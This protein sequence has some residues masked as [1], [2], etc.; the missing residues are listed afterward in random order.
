MTSIAILGHDGAVRITSSFSAPSLNAIVADRGT[1]GSPVPIT[2]KTVWSINPHNTVLLESSDSNARIVWDDG[3]RR[4]LYQSRNTSHDVWRVQYAWTK[5][6]A[7]ENLKGSLQWVVPN[8]DAHQDLAGVTA[9]AM[10]TVNA[11][12]SQPSD[13]K[14]SISESDD[15]ESSTMNEQTVS[16]I[17]PA[18]IIDDASDDDQKSIDDFSSHET[19]APITVE[20]LEPDTAITVDDHV[21]DDSTAITTVSAAAGIDGTDIIA[22]AS[23]DV[24]GMIALIPSRD[25]VERLAIDG[26]ETKDQ[27][28][29]TLTYLGKRAGGWPDDIRAA[30]IDNVQTIAR[31]FTPISAQTFF[32]TVFNPSGDQPCVVL[33]VTGDDLPVIMRE[34]R[35][36]AYDILGDDVPLQHSPWIPHITLKYLQNE[37]VDIQSFTDT[38]IG[39]VTFDRIRVAFGDSY[40]D[41]PLGEDTTMSPNTSEP[42]T[43][44]DTPEWDGELSFDADGHP[45]VPNVLIPMHV[46]QKERDVNEPSGVG[47]NLRNYWVRGEG[48][49]KIRWGTDGS[50]QRCIRYLSDYVVDPGGLCAEYHHAATGEWPRGGNVPSGADVIAFEDNM[51]DGEHK[52]DDMEHGNDDNESMPWSG[53][54][55]VEGI[56]SGDGRVFAPYALTWDDPPL[57]LL[58]QKETSHGGTNDVTVRVGNIDKIWREPDPSGRRDVFFI[59]GAGT[60]DLGNPDGAEIYRRMRRGYMRGNSVDVDSVRDADVQYVY[61]ETPRT[62]G[63]ND[64]ESGMGLDD[65]AQL[66]ARPETM[67]FTKGRIRATTLVEIPAFTEA[68]LS[69]DD[70]ITSSAFASHTSSRASDAPWNAS[71]NLRRLP[72]PVP[73]DVARNVFAWYDEDFVKDGGIPKHAGRFPHHEV[74]ADGTPGAVNLVACSGVIGALNGARGGSSIP[75]SE[76]RAVYNHIAKHMRDADRTPPPLKSLSAVNNLTLTAGAVRAHKTET[77]DTSWDSGVMTKRLSSPLSVADARNVFAWIDESRV[78]DGMMPKGAGKLP[79]HEVNADGTPGPAN[80]TACSAAIGA[81][82]GARGGVDIPASDRQ[83]VYNHLASHLRDA[84]R[85]PPALT[86]S[87]FS[88]DNDALIA[89]TSTITISDVPPREWFDEP[90]DVTPSGALTVT[91]DGRIF[92]YIAPANVRHRSFQD[93]AT[94]VPMKKV[95]YSRFMGGETIVADGGRIATGNITMGCG[96]A[97][98]SPHV[99][100]V[101]AAEHYDNTCS[102]VATVRVGENQH[103]VWMAGALL[104]GLSADHVRRIMACRLSGDWRPHLDRPG[105]REFV[106]ALLVPVP[107]FPM[108]RTA[109][110]VSTRNGALIASSVPVQFILDDTLSDDNVEDANDASA[111]IASDDVNTNVAE[112]QDN[113]PDDASNVESVTCACKD[114]KKA[115]T[116]NDVSASACD[117]VSVQNDSSVQPHVDDIRAR[118]AALRAQHIISG[119]RTENNID[120]N[121]AR[122][123]AL[124]KRLGKEM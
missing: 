71:L 120:A 29:L 70:A 95:D 36:I 43:A 82:N 27:L 28:H 21:D 39:N 96:H 48:A 19:H 2:T 53:V 9:D 51:M 104:P 93:R 124:R 107:G 116:S 45:V 91:S 83:A 15:V 87:A 44:V 31:S 80:L 106:A 40:Q 24:P 72:T 108:P 8:L 11:S 66:F 41:M 67:I 14:Q 88:D 97:S 35:Q 3:L 101:A 90:N 22:A 7:Y 122:I 84:G 61:P 26:G 16:R 74:S 42:V 69:L 59:Y 113:A 63:E 89:A 47:H 60:I 4:Y 99:D 13:L 117:T 76:R 109:P 55:T 32:T 57:P 105:W 1:P 100:A 79:H 46:F 78:S 94:Y 81:L 58:W 52:C 64:D 86:S 98:V 54:L 110:S 10:G 62:G 68:R 6:E 18:A 25:D 121:V 92:G 17:E 85:K 119:T 103:G 5:R 56:E 114:R 33:G 118:I 37:S 12:D 34:S 75:E 65:F 38:H 102:I 50:M 111:L 73:M 112:S 30:C 123:A 77:I 49:A 23:T 115:F 20:E